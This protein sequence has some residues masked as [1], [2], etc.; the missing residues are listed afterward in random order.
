[1]DALAL[2]AGIGDAIIDSEATPAGAHQ[3]GPHDPA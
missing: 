1:M 2:V 3:E